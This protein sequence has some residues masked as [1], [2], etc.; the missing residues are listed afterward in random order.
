MT[1]TQQLTK[2]RDFRQNYHFDFHLWTRNGA[3]WTF[4]DS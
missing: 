2:S 4:N 3:Y 1:V